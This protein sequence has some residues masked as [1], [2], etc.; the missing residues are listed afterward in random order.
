[1]L[2]LQILKAGR[3]QTNNIKCMVDVI[4]KIIT[5]LHGK[6]FSI[7]HALILSN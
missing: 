4:N 3:K 1:M 6:C 2:L 7:V 5:Y